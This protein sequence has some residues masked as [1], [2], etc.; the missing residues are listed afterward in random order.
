[1]PYAW[2]YAADISRISTNEKRTD[3]FMRYVEWFN[4]AKLLIFS[5]FCLESEALFSLVP[6]RS[7]PYNRFTPSCHCQNG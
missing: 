6:P 3:N 7:C 4:D 2:L 1:M 5:Y